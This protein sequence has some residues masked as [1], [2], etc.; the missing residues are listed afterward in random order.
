[1]AVCAEVDASG[2]VDTGWSQM[3]RYG[4]IIIGT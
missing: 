1:M 2:G 4:A 3:K